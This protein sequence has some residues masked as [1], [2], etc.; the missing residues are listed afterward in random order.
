MDSATEALLETIRAKLRA[1]LTGRTAGGQAH[2]IRSLR[3]LAREL[4]MSP[5]G[6]AK[7]IDGAAPYSATLRSVTEWYRLEVSGS[8]AE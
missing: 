6:L 8:R 5:S 4:E 1:Y 2:P 3:R 7:F